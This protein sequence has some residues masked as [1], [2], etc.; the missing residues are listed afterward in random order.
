MIG[1]E[2]SIYICED[3]L[4]RR[5]LQATSDAT[6]TKRGHE[7]VARR[8]QYNSQAKVQGGWHSSPSFERQNFGRP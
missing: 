3:G 4:A 7:R 8:G 6:V 1:R 2:S 5:W